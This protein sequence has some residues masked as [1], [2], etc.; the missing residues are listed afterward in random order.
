MS[1]D[2]IQK[3]LGGYATGTL[4]PDEQQ[5]LFEAAL[6]DQQL[7]DALA[8]EEALRDVLSDP[9]ARAHLLAA[10]DEAPA[11]WYRQWWRPSLVMAAALAIVVGVAL[12][13]RSGAPK[14]E[15]TAKVE[16]PRFRPPVETR[17][18]PVLPP[19]P[20]LKRSVQPMKPLSLP[21][22][23]PAAVPS[24]PPPAPPIALSSPPPTQPADAKLEQ[25]DAFTVSGSASAGT[26][27]PKQQS[28]QGPRQQQTFQAVPQAAPAPA[29]RL[30]EPA[31][32]PLRGVV[33]DASGD[34][35]QSASVVVKSLATGEVVKAS[36]DDR[37]EFNASAAPGSAIQVSASAPGYRS[38]TV[39]QT[40]PASGTPEP[41][42]LRLDIGSTASTV[43]VT[44]QSSES[45]APRAAVGGGGGRGG[46]GRISGLAGA[47]PAGAKKAKASTP[48]LEYHLL[49]RIS[50]GDSVEVPAD[51]SVPAGANLILRVTPA[52]DGYFRIV[53]G[54]GSAIASPKVRRGVPYETALPPFDRPGRVELQVFFS[55][56]ATEK[57]DESPS[58]TIAF[59]IQ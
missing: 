17:S 22:A 50:G 46:A 49:R 19:P 27:P 42:N 41:V 33:T 54:T 45:L 44:A 39:S 28:Q 4:T 25:R 37:G 5:A 16:L 29:N 8:R 15:Q 38:M 40:V 30:F 13:D 57:K 36:T 9:A 23:P 32:V 24:P 43:E 2:D 59:S 3:L 58:L 31:T 35:I 12:W 18:T 34:R 26:Q 6:S 51:G 55:A 56:Q 10:M 52:A 14:V 11:P 48:A 1:R 53:A 7:F 21:G 47:A 20:E